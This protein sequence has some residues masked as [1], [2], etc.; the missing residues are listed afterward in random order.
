MK[1]RLALAAATCLALPIAA[2]A[3]PVTGPYVSLEG[4]TSISNPFNYDYYAVQDNGGPAYQGPTGKFLS[5]PAYAGVGSIGYG[6]GNGF[7]VELG[8]NFFRNTI[9]KDD[10]SGINGGQYS[11]TGGMNTYGPMVNVLYD[12]NIGL[13]I[14]PYVGAGVGYQW[15]KFSSRINDIDSCRTT[16]SRV[17]EAVSLMTL[18]AACLIRCQWCRACHL[19]RN[20]A[21]CS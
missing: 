20:T 1:L 21:S 18:S 12:M 6:F 17:Q 4:G 9:H 14:Y 2:H 15:V 11:A 19:Q 10:N 16:R 7:R 8:G 5:R 3:Q 13:P